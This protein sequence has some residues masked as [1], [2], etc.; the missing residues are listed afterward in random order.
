MKM[1]PTSA[2]RAPPTTPPYAAPRPA[3]PG[4]LSGLPRLAGP[5]RI[6][7]VEPS[8]IQPGRR[9]ARRPMQSGSDKSAKHVHSV[10]PCEDTGGGCP[11]PRCAGLPTATDHCTAGNRGS[12]L[13]D[14][15]PRLRAGV[16]CSWTSPARRRALFSRGRSRNVG[17]E[18]HGASARSRSRGQADQFHRRSGPAA[19][20]D[21]QRFAYNKTFEQ[22]FASGIAGFNRPT[23]V[24]FGP[25][26]CAYIADYE[27]IRDPGQ[28]DP[29][30]KVPNPADAAFLQI[31]GTGVIWKICPQ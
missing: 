25:D 3:E 8:S 29:D 12:R 31:P 19:C 17:G 30:M 9:T 7:A 15:R 1:A 13:V 18:C 22:A 16:F 2:G 4:R 24:R 14:H 5:L 21:L 28:S 11:G 20:P 6:F 26:G 10:E 23:N 27:A